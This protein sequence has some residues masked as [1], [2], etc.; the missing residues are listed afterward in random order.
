MAE[1]SIH[2]EF[3]SLAMEGNGAE[4]ILRTL[5]RFTG[6]ETAFVDTWFKE[7]F[8]WPEDGEA[9]RLLQHGAPEQPDPRFGQYP[10]ANRE[11]SFGW[12][13]YEKSAESEDIQTA[14]EYAAVALILRCQTRIADQQMAAKYKEVFLEDLLLN[15]VKADMEIHNRA[16]LYGWDFS[17]GALAAVVDI[18]N[19]K[20]YF[21]DTLDEGT[22]QMLEQA[23]EG[24]FKLS[25]AEMRST[26]PESKYLQQSDLIVF[27]ISAKA[28]ERTKLAKQLEETFLRLQKRVAAESHFTI[29]LGVG[30]YYENIRDISKSYAEART[31]INLGYSLQWFDRILFYNQ[32]GLY[33][34]LAPMADRPEAQELMERC[35]RPLED[36]DQKHNS[37]L[38]HTLQIVI[39]QGWNLKAAAEELYIHYN[40]VKY[41][42]AKICRLLGIDLAVHDNRTLVEI[43]LKLHLLRTPPQHI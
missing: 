27:L 2:R 39:Q 3:L 9:A 1:H 11:R 24:I 16:R 4:E 7:S 43:A 31:A 30:Q 21:V 18:N 33:R 25:I 17:Q 35:I 6:G 22:N 14:L 42:Y 34:L 12:L 13:I 37:E 15:N 23:T 8:C 36:Y 41:R 26:F 40:S 20:K 5:S 28:K 32:L 19:I 38:L 10:V 29:T